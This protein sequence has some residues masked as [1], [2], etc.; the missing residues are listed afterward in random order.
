MKL[1]KHLINGTVWSLLAL[2]LLLLIASRLPVC[3][4]FAGSKI[5]SVLSKQLGTEVSVGRI[6]IG[7]LNRLI[8]DDV[9]IKD[10]QQQEMLRISRLTARVGLRAL[11]KGKIYI[12]SAQL[13]G[14]QA[15]LYQKS[16]Q[17]KPNY[18]F[19]ID[20]LASKDTTSHTYQLAHHTP[21]GHPL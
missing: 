6:D 21:F 1:I 19:V 18:Q 7:L 16:G 12:A 17:D 15:N 3:Q 5:A 4:E 14:A 11:A 8:L 2:Y 13:F 9:C 10:Q 20:S